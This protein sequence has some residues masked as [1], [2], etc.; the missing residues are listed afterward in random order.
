MGSVYK[1]RTG[2]SE[3][4]SLQAYGKGMGDSGEEAASVPSVFTWQ[5]QALS[6]PLRKVVLLQRSEK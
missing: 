6:E 1:W 4:Q 5:P 2:K 3:S